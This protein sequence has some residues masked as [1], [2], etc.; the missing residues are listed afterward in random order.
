MYT[1]YRGRSAFRDMNP[2]LQ[3]IVLDKPAVPDSS[4]R[5]I[6][7]IDTHHG[8]KSG[9]N[10]PSRIPAEISEDSRYLID[11]THTEVDPQNPYSEQ[12]GALSG[13]GLPR[14]RMY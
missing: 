5:Y 12:Q 4:K 8:S 9:Y 10:R 11:R 14:Q 13:H 3:Q 2:G 7:R 6:I 1:F